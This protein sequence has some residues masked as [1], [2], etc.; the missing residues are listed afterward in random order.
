[1][2]EHCSCC[3]AALACTGCGSTDTIAEMKIKHPKA[4]LCCP[5]RYMR[6]INHDALLKAL[7]DITAMDPKGIRADD[8]GRAARIAREAVRGHVGGSGNG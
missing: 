1:M 3:G 2:A 6:A 5:D 4:L 8:L 7:E